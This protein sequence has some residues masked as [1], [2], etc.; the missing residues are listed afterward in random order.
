MF[1]LKEVLFKKDIPGSEI[2]EQDE[3]Q[4]IQIATC[5]LL[6]EVAKSDDEFSSIEKT[7]ISAVLK[8]KFQMSDEA[9]EELMKIAKGR[10]EESIDLW[11]FTNLINEN[12][13]RERKIRL[14]EAAWRVIYADRK[15]DK[16][17]DHLVHKLAKLLRLE[18]KDMIEAKVR[19]LDEI[20]S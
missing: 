12:Y 7:T 19:V 10:R 2:Q 18:H 20:R 14:V 3:T 13:P 16:Y 6:L 4:R 9:A 17:E 11:E 1:K 15:L 8:K 5:V